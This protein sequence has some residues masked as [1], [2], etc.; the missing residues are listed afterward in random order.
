M[1]AAHDVT[2]IRLV[3]QGQGETLVAARVWKRIEAHE[4]LP[5]E[6]VTRG[7]LENRH[8]R[9]QLIEVAA[10]LMHSLEMLAQDR[11]QVTAL[12][13]PSQVI[14]SLPELAHL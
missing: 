3:E 10:D 1:E 4:P 7:T 11:L 9:S 6:V 5:S 8:S 2:V 12:N 14:D 13:A